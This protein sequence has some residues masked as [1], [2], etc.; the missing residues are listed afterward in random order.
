MLL[1]GLSVNV[2]LAGQPDPKT[3]ARGMVF[4]TA[5]GGVGGG[6][7]AFTTDGMKRERVEDGV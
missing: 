1:R 5:L 7:Q 3:V 6:V 2:P 4:Y